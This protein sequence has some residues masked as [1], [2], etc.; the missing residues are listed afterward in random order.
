[1]PVEF[2][3][4][5]YRFGHS[6]VRPSYHLNE[7]E[8][9]KRDPLRQRK[10]AEETPF[11]VPIFDANEP[12]L[13]GFRPLQPHAKA[14][15]A[16]VQPFSF[17]IDWRFFFDG[18]G[19]IEI[20]KKKFG[21]QP[22][23]KI[24]TKLVEPLALLNV[25]GAVPTDAARSHF[26]SLAFRNLQRGV[27]LGLPSGQDVARK[28]GLPPLTG[29]QVWRTVSEDEV[30]AANWSLMQ[31]AGLPTHL[32][33]YVAAKLFTASENEQGPDGKPLSKEA[34]WQKVKAAVTQLEQA[35]PLW[36]YILREGEFQPARHTNPEDKPGKSFGA[37]LGSVGARI[38]AEVFLGLLAG[39]NQAF[40]SL[41]PNWT[42]AQSPLGLTD[43]LDMGG[44]VKFA[45]G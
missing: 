36:F 24:D 4:A 21:P 22:S 15:P 45:L 8:L 27:S 20:G 7:D 34:R 9:K 14:W 40:L 33:S 13:N 26:H 25:F 16:G 39:D 37:R 5:V 41:D 18:L 19:P 17:V 29:A 11:R 31:L 12:N 23:Y 2:S 28:M 6:M 1:M 3:G 35:T 32:G 44:F 42:P 10:E 38:V 43:K 30:D